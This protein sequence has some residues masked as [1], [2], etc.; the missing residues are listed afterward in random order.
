MNI[1]NMYM[2]KM[3]KNAFLNKPEEIE[4]KD[5]KMIPQIL[6]NPIN[7]VLN[8]KMMTE[9]SPLEMMKDALKESLIK[10]DLVKDTMVKD[11]IVK[12]DLLK[13][14]YL[15]KMMNRNFFPMINRFNNNKM[16]SDDLLLLQNKMEELIPSRIRRHANYVQIPTTYNYNK[17]LKALPFFY[18]VPTTQQ[19]YYTQPTAYTN[20]VGATQYQYTNTVGTPVQYTNTI[21]FQYTNTIG[22]P[23]QYNTVGNTP[24]TYYYPTQTV[25]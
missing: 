24:Y 6:V 10:D 18:N 13:K 17:N 12:D 11:T 22:S 21:P 14:F 4:V 3:M 20:T 8:E 9:E 5:I 15:E 19:V 25:V 7:K 16:T 2:D 23:F 1:Q